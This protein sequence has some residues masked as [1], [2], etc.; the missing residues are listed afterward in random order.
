MAKNLFAHPEY[1]GYTDAQDGEVSA[2]PPNDGMYYIAAAAGYYAALVY[3]GPAIEAG[4]TLEFRVRHTPNGDPYNRDATGY[5]MLLGED[6]GGIFE[7]SRSLFA[8][9]GYAAVE[10]NISVPAPSALK[11]LGWV[12][13]EGVPYPGLYELLMPGGGP[14]ACFWTDLVNAKQECEEAPVEGCY[15]ISIQN[16]DIV[17]PADQLPEWWGEQQVELEYDFG[18]EQGWYTFFYDEIEDRYIGD[19]QYYECDTSYPNTQIR[20]YEDA[21]AGPLRTGCADLEVSCH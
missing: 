12:G 18:G 14:P 5:V 6:G 3:V 4:D 2:A 13:G 9:D 1:W 10:A 15:A 21:G 7:I 8:A 17:Y 20:W 19:I 11:Y 16:G